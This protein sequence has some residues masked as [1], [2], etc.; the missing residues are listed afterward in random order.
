MKGE[1]EEE[2]IKKEKDK[3][4]TNSRTIQKINFTENLN[5]ENTLKKEKEKLI[6]ARNLKNVN[7]IIV[8]K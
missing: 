6:I 2:R 3:L 5:Q 8:E 7:V 1:Q 4:S